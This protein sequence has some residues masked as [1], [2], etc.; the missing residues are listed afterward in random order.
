ME[1][2]RPPAA[3]SPA[4]DAEMGVTALEY[5]PSG[6]RGKMIGDRGRSVV[7]CR[8]LPCPR[9]LETVALGAVI[10]ALN[11]VPPY[12][13]AYT[14]QEQFP[15]LTPDQL[16]ELNEGALTPDERRELE[17][18]RLQV[19]RLARDRLSA[20]DGGRPTADGA[21]VPPAWEGDDWQELDRQVQR[22]LRFMYGRTEADLQEV[23]QA[24]WGED[25][26]DVTEAARETTTSKANNFLRKRESPRLLRKVRGENCL[27]WK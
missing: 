22:L 27:R 16:R 10:S 19:I 9:E 3:R 2:S 17:K 7:H 23:C 15:G 18:T 24:V 6:L 25:C 12:E 11:R 20:L 1:L 5:L 4:S 21:A 13:P 8:L 14:P 26:A